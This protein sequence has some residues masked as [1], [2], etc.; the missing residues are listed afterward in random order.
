MKITRSESNG[1]LIVD[2]TGE[3]PALLDY[4]EQRTKLDALINKK[5]KE[6]EEHI[7]KAILKVIDQDT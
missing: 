1:E 2:L 6:F 3:S 5:S 4:A 7:R